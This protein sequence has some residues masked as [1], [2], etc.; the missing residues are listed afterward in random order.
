MKRL[1]AKNGKPYDVPEVPYE[2]HPSY[3]GYQIQWE[4]PP[5][6]PGNGVEW[7]ATQ[8]DYPEAP[9]LMDDTVDGLKAQIDE[10]IEERE[11]A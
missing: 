6:P 8:E 2:G 9:C 7:S 4:R 5:V 11:E 10:H 3:R 1:T